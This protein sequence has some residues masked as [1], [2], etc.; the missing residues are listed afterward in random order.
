MYNPQFVKQVQLL[1]K[2][3][4]A[5][6]HQSDFALKGG[7]AI[8][9]FIRDLP[10]LSV[11]IDLTYVPLT[12][13]EE[14]LNAIQAGLRNIAKLI[15][16]AYPEFI[17]KEQLSRQNGYVLKL[18]IYHQST[19]IKIE[20]NFVMRGTL[21]PLQKSSLTSKASD[22]FSAFIDEV[23]L[24]ATSEVYAGKLCAALSRQHPRDLFDVKLLFDKGGITDDLRQAF[25]VY[26][27]SDSRPIHELLAPNRIDITA[28]FKRDFARMTENEVTLA[29]LINVREQLIQTI[30]QVLTDKERGFLLS[31][32]RGEPDFSLM[33]FEHLDQ[34]PALKWKVINVKN[35]EKQ[36][37][38]IMLNKLKMILDC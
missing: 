12:D 35:M 11:D 34:L 5:I 28:L 7:T 13:R 33:P 19:A 17:I 24:L 27:A 15:K 22:T 30:N 31:V 29:D 6:C 36:K 3:L 37:H 14:S 23:P 9:L 4:P 20:P 26:L 2:C 25:V 32:K 8:N 21:Y 38:Q 10:R 18:L 1:L 16:E